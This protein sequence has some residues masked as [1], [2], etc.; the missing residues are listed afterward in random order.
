MGEVTGEVEGGAG[1]VGTTGG[2]G[3]RASDAA[4]AEVMSR[5]AAGDAA[6]VLTLREAFRDDLA[7]AVRRVAR[8]RRARLDAD[9]VDELVTDVVLELAR[10]APSWKP[11]GAPPWVWAHHRVAAVVD[12]HVGQW[13]RPFDD[14]EHRCHD[15]SAVPAAPSTEP[16]VL[17]V[18]DGLA[19]WCPAAALLQ[20]AVERV[21]SPRDRE[22]FFEHA[23]QA[24]LGDRSPAT[25]VARSM[26]L[27]PEAV[28]QQAHRVRER[29]RRLAAAEPRFAALA[30][31]AVVA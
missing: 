15:R 9:T 11:G 17:V 2:G 26:G 27:E 6:A 24:A 7:G 31:L 14:A 5:L 30:E 21:A 16:D 10:L 3:T 22:L 12:R 19:G 25:T 13:T 29:V 4:L 1:V 18:L 20:E 8:R 23:V 28:R